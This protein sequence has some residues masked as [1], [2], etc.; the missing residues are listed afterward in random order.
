MQD[1][2][3]TGHLDII[4]IGPQD[5]GDYCLKID[6]QAIHLS[7]AGLVH[8]GMVFTMLDAA[9]GRAVI[10]QLQRGYSSPTIEMKI[11]YFRPASAGELIARG[12]VVNQ[13]KQLCYA[14]GE[15]VNGEGKLIARATGTFFIKPMS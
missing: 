9:L 15:V 3:Y 1:I 7:R 5:D 6:L 11:N 14:E 4:D 10:N 12:R 2:E 8:G 13:S